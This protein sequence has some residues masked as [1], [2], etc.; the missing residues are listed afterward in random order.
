MHLFD[1][2]KKRIPKYLTREELLEV[3]L[4][5]LKNLHTFCVNN[6]I[7]YYLA[8]GTL[9][10]AV[11]HKGFIPWDDDV[12]IL[13]PYQDWLRFRD[14][15]KDKRYYVADSFTDVRHSLYFGRFY[16]NYTC[17]QGFQKMLGAFIDI[18]CMHGLPDVK[19]NG[20][21]Q[22]A[23][24]CKMDHLRKQY[25]KA[26]NWFM[27]RHLW[28]T[29]HPRYSLLTNIISRKIQKQLSKYSMTD[30][31]IVFAY[32]GDGLDEVF[33]SCLFGTPILLQFED[34]S[35]YVPEHYNEL[36]TIMYG[37]YM[38]LPPEEQRHPYHGSET[39]TWK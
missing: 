19:F 13:M 2:E 21:N 39:F 9:L 6:G 1:F 35:F 4:D 27:Y 22:V 14:S 26:R 5:M 7:T 28:P 24:V 17:R 31:Q 34:S 33:R 29:L 3:Q 16:D 20:V 32:G 12:D 10:G 25:M 30:S 15:Y 18:Y 38:Q 37:D 8:Y 23:K 11:R 36:L